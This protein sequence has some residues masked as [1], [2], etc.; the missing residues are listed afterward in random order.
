MY[1]KK[2][3][4]LRD[5]R[6]LGLLLVLFQ[7]QLVAGS[8]LKVSS[9]HEANTNIL[10]V[11]SFCSYRVCIDLGGQPHITGMQPNIPLT[12]Y[13]YC[14][15][16][17]FCV[18]GIGYNRFIS[19]LNAYLASVGDPG[20]ARFDFSYRG[21]RGAMLLIEGTQ[22]NF[23]ILELT[24]F[25]TGN[26][27]PYPFTKYDCRTG[28]D[29]CVPGGP[30]DDGNPNT[31]GDVYNAECECVGEEF[32]AEVD[33]DDG[34]DLTVDVVNADCTVT[35]IPPDTDDGCD[36]TTDSFDPV[37]CAVVNTPPDVDD[38][39]EGTEDYF[40]SVNCVIV[41][42]PLPCDDRN[43]MTVGDVY[44]ENCECVGCDPCKLEGEQW[45]LLCELLTGKI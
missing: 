13:P 32:C 17:S 15:N 8:E 9:I 12:G 4:R 10:L 26:R 23:D 18:G 1:G 34:C 36:L 5:F 21:C 39:C 33:P 41:N 35:N 43:P 31:T 14:M 24:D 7:V 29:P 27:Y 20:V 28:P 45:R 22:L 6:W 11:D 3:I 16:T 37:L 25:A 2:N 30:C 42:T 40:D 44:D 38:G 19:D